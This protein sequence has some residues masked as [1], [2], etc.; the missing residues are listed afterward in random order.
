MIKKSLLLATLISSSIFASYFSTQIIF[1]I[2]CLIFLKLFKIRFFIASI[3]VFLLYFLSIKINSEF[4]FPGNSIY[5]LRMTL[6]Y[7]T[8]LA[9]LFILPKNLVLTTKQK[10]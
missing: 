1:I 8:V 9:Y 2:S 4:I 7:L 5:A 6:P 10:I 3:V